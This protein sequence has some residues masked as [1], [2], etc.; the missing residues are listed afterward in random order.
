MTG[1]RE[2]NK[3]TRLWVGANDRATPSQVDRSRRFDVLQAL[4][5][6]VPGRDRLI[7]SGRSPTSPGE[8]RRDLSAL[9]VPRIGLVRPEDEFEKHAHLA[10]RLDR[11]TSAG[12]PGA[13]RSD[14]AAP[15]AS[16]R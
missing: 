1:W 3:K 8:V 2:Q 5:G 7:I 4:L 16:E 11:N 15:R 6:E 12:G 9:R 10:V 13:P 14:S